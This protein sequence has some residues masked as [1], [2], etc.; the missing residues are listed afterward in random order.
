M[1]ALRMLAGKSAY[2]KIENNGLTPALIRGVIGASGGPKWLV[3]RGLDGYIF[4]KWLPQAK[5]TFDLIGSSIG[6]WRMTLAALKDPSQAF[7]RFEEIYFDYRYEQSE[8]PAKVTALSYEMLEYILPADKCVEALSNPRRNLNIVAV[9]CKAGT[10]SSNIVPL[11][12]ATLLAA[13]LNGISRSSLSMFYDRVILHSFEHG[14]QA[15]QDFNR[16][17]IHLRP[18]RLHAALLASG[19]IPFVTEAIKDL[20]GPDKNSVYRDG[21]VIDYHF[22]ED[23]QT[24]DGIML[25]PHFYDHLVPGW[26]DKSLPWRRTPSNLL[27]NI[28]L[29]CPAKGY[30]DTS[31]GGKIPDRSNFRAMENDVRL[32]FWRK[33]VDE[34]KRLADEFAELTSDHG[35]LMDRLEKV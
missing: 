2:E 20:G 8:T 26:F 31:L 24:G 16:S 3:L 6:A 5:Q 9:R 7:D 1:K 35:L 33:T 34:G 17:D 11:V 12:G 22:D 32:A 28:L 19:S 14:T 25:Y 27:D 10:G 29:A 21:G 13:T 23:W 18:D 30:V 15:L 4:G